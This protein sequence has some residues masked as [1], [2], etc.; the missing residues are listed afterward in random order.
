MAAS[1]LKWHECKHADSSVVCTSYVNVSQIGLHAVNKEF[2]GQHRSP[3]CAVPCAGALRKHSQ[4]CRCGLRVSFA[5][6][7]AIATS[8]MSTPVMCHLPEER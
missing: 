6:A 5:C 1:P 3:P 8:V 4:G 7:S 2:R